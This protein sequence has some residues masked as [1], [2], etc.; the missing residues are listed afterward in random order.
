[1]PRLLSIGSSKH[2]FLAGSNIKIIWLDFWR[3]QRLLRRST[4]GCLQT[5]QLTRSG[6]NVT[7][8]LRHRI[9]ICID[10]DVVA[11]KNY[12]FTLWLTDG[13]AFAYADHVVRYCLQKQRSRWPKSDAYLDLTSGSNDPLVAGS[14]LTVFSKV[15]SVSPRSEVGPIFRITMHLVRPGAL[16]VKAF[17]VS[18]LSSLL[19]ILQ[20]DGETGV[21]CPGNV[22]FTAL[23]MSLAANQFPKATFARVSSFLKH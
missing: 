1:M 10:A 4:N 12:A 20:E 23:W 8:T 11:I 5:S 22:A 17:R 21:H 2:G 3:L 7:V 6:N 18:T 13:S 9:Q 14:R 19:C 15:W 16:S